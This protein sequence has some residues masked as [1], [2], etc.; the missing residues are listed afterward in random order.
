MSKSKVRRSTKDLQSALKDEIEFLMT[1]C[2]EYD[3]GRRYYSKQ[4]SA[5]LRRLIYHGQKG[6]PMLALLGIRDS[7]RYL[8]TAEAVDKN[9]P[10]AQWPLCQLV[11]V[12]DWA[13]GTEDEQ[14][15][16]RIVA[17]LSTIPQTHTWKRF[18]DWWYK[19]TVVL[20]KNRKKFNRHEMVRLMANQEGA[21]QD[22]ELE[23]E[24]MALSRGDGSGWVFGQEFS[25]KPVLGVHSGSVRQIAHELVCSLYHYD[26]DLFR[27]NYE[28][29]PL[30]V[31]KGR[32]L[33]GLSACGIAGF[34]LSSFD[35]SKSEDK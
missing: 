2:R 32:T 3:L 8:N 29:D 18:K 21:H 31:L 9:S 20:T 28:P 25:G 33:L 26:P 17:R 15:R 5:S 34:L 13:S 1:S 14:N 12:G 6:T 4:I 23:A 7:F 30:G 16:E 22:A 11:E 27:Q 19:Q 35:P 10:H 24:Y